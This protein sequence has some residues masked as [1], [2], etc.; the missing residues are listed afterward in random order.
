MLKHKKKFV[1]MLRV[2][3]FT[4]INPLNAYRADVI[5]SFM[6]SI[7]FRSVRYIYPLHCDCEWQL[8][9]TRMSFNM[10][11]YHC[12][13]ELNHTKFVYIVKHTHI[14]C[15]RPF[16]KSIRHTSKEILHSSLTES[17]L[18][19]NFSVMVKPHCCFEN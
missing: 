3:E 10:Q 17:N 7:L 16:K 8:H 11:F 12:L 4:C 2:S 6:S 15:G 18:N 1:S 14:L 9:N 5:P 19:L 13:T